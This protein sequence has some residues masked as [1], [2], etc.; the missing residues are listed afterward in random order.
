MKDFV[1]LLGRPGCGKSFIYETI[2]SSLKETG[3]VK[4][5]K[6]VDDFPF[7]KEILD[8][9][10]EFKRHVRKEGGFEVTDWSIVDEVLQLINERLPQ[11][12][13]DCDVVFIEFARDKYFK[14]FKNFSSDILSRSLLLYIF[15]LKGTE[16]VLKKR[17]KTIP[18]T[19]L[20]QQTLCIPT[21][22]TMT[23][24]KFI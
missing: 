11:I 13:K 15:A 12:K 19:T 6:R 9:D 23:L 10:T 8:R 7:L 5:V 14:A 21:T 20:S 1:F 17:A 4:N 18:M 24:R 2:V 22:K 16:G 3:I